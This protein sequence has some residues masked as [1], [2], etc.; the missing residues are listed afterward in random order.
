MGRTRLFEND[1]TAFDTDW[2]TAGTTIFQ[3]NYTHGNRGGFWLDCTGIN[4][5]R[6]CKGT[7][8][9]YNISVDDE[10][11]LIQDDYGIRSELYGNL[12]LH[13]GEQGPM[14]CCHQ[15][16]QSHLFYRNIFAFSGH[17]ALG[18]QSSVFRGNW[19]GNLM[20]LPED[21]E[22]RGGSPVELDGLAERIVESEECRRQIWDQLAM[23]AGTLADI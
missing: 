14:I 20:Q 17:P 18:W 21:P 9:R 5:N 15:P 7:I 10:R 12:F 13:T 3:Y 11:C 1:G 6:E 4:R 19:Y 8:L 16:G 23:A 2:G 22:A